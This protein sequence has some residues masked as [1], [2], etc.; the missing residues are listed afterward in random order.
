VGDAVTI[1]RNPVNDA[2]FER[3]IAEAM[4]PDLQDPEVLQRSLRASYPQAVVRPRG[5]TG[6]RGIVWYVYR[7]GHWVSGR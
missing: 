4:H 6:E 7:E 2:E 1:V 3:A 5:L